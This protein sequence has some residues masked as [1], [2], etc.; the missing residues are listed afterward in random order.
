[1]YVR[2]VLIGAC[3][4]LFCLLA[5]CQQPAMSEMMQQPERPAALDKLNAWVGTWKGEATMTV[6]KTGE[7]MTMTGTSE[8]RWA[9]DDWLMVEEATMTMEGGEEMKGI[10]VWAYDSKIKK[11]RFW[12]FT[13]W[14]MVAEGT[15]W[16]DADENEWVMH[17]KSR[18]LASGHAWKSRGKAKFVHPNTVEYESAEYVGLIPMKIMEMEGVSQRQ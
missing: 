7:Q 15:A 4:I 18:D 6:P 16:Y 8:S 3:A 10:G 11:Y 13:N 9:A 14:N 5:G 12:W 1:M 17:G 2:T